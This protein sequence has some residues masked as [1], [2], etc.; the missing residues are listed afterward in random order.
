MLK[1]DR[2][3]EIESGSTAVVPQ[4]PSPTTMASLWRQTRALLVKNLLIKKR[5]KKQ[6]AFEVR[7]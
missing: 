1:K 2:D 3:K 5:Y 4:L 7:E 6:T